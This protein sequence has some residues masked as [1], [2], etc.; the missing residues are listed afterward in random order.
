MNND[1]HDESLTHA[2]RISRLSSLLSRWY[3]IAVNYLSRVLSLFSFAQLAIL[4]HSGLIGRRLVVL[5]H[6]CAEDVERFYASILFNPLTETSRSSSENDDLQ[7][8][9]GENSSSHQLSLLESNGFC[10]EWARELLALPFSDPLF[11]PLACKKLLDDKKVG[12]MNSLNY[13]NK[14]VNLAK[15]DHYALFTAYCELISE[16]N[17]DVLLILLLRDL[18]PDHDPDF[19]TRE[20][21]SVIHTFH[22]TQDRLGRVASPPPMNLL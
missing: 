6:E 3:D 22:T 11:N 17:A 1:A 7:L 5:S 4:L 10:E 15:L 18:T 8:V 14:L 20:V 19:A 9:L 21:L 13:V 12:I 16:N 2:N